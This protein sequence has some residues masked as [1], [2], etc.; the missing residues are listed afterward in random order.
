[1]IFWVFVRGMPLNRKPSHESKW[2]F[3]CRI[4]LPARTP[5]A[6][7]FLPFLQGVASPT[8]LCSSELPSCACSV[9]TWS[10]NSFDQVIQLV[11]G[12]TSQGKGLLEREIED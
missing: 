3:M 9:I 5:K 11:A 2:R 10:K 6:S 8:V 7:T 1:M 12:T 4:L